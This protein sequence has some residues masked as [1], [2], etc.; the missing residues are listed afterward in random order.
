MNAKIKKA[1]QSDKI[2]V[3]GKQQKKKSTSMDDIG[4]LALQISC[5][6]RIEI[7]T[8]DLSGDSEPLS[9]FFC[10]NIETRTASAVIFIGTYDEIGIDEVVARLK[11]QILNVIKSSNEKIYFLDVVKINREPIPF[12]EML[13]RF[14][15]YTFLWQMPNVDMVVSY[16]RLGKKLDSDKFESVGLDHI[17]DEPSQVDLYLHFPRNNRYVHYL[18]KGVKLEKGRKDRLNQKGVKN[19]FSPKDQPVDRQKLRVEAIIA[20]LLKQLNTDK[21]PA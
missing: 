13:V 21:M 9:E 18:K 15:E 12:V 5:P 17:G 7:K 16:I 10:I 20:D 2:F 4:L 11:D 3:K 19:L 8:E 6:Y 1:H 14:S